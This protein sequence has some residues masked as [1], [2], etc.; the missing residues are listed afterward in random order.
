M[1]EDVKNYLDYIH[2]LDEAKK[3]VRERFLV[4]L[5]CVAMVEM[6]LEFEE[7][8]NELMPFFA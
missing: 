8:L 4:L 1:N 3:S 6:V 2:F 7:E 5:D